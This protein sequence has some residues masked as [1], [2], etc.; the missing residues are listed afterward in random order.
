MKRTSSTGRSFEYVRY[1]SR[2][3]GPPASVIPSWTRAFFTSRC[4]SS[5]NGVAGPLA[6][7]APQQRA[8]KWNSPTFDTGNFSL[9]AVNSVYTP[10][11]DAGIIVVHFKDTPTTQGLLK[12]M[13][14]GDTI[15]FSERDSPE[16]FDNIRHFAETG[17]TRNVFSDSNSTKPPETDTTDMPGGGAWTKLAGDYGMT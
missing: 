5:L 16:A 14:R 1:T 2:S 6:A 12:N 7:R 4:F 17:D 11:K 3:E 15:I 9:S 10:F 13:F 8:H